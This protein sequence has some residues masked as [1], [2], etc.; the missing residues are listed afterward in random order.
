MKR[1]G[2][3][4]NMRRKMQELFRSPLSFTPRQVVQYIADNRAKYEP[5]YREVYLD[6]D[7]PFDDYI[8]LQKKD[9]HVFLR[10]GK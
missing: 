2:R 4:K 7:K 3:R 6:T 9:S 8:R 5:M 1:L 10:G